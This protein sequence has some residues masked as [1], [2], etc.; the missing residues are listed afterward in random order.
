M[1]QQLHSQLFEVLKYLPRK[2]RK[3]VLIMEYLNESEVCCKSASSGAKSNLGTVFPSLRGIAL[4]GEFYI[5]PH[6]DR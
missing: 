2:Y 4:T 6:L 1:L 3:N 5:R